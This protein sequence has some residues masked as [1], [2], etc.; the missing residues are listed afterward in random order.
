MK[1]LPLLFLLLISSIKNFAQVGIGTT[2]PDASSVLDISGSNKGV[3]LPKVALTNI[4]SA[5]PIANP[6]I[7]LLIYNTTT[8]GTTPNNLAPGYYVWSGVRWFP[9]INKG[10]NPGDMQYWDGTKWIMIP[11]GANGSVLTICN[12]IPR[13]GGCPPPVIDT[14]IPANNLYEGDI[15]STSP[16]GWFGGT[17][18]IDLHA[19]TVGGNPIYRRI[20]I[21]FNYPS[22]PVGTI[23]DSCKLYFYSSPVPQNGNGVDAQYGANSSTVQRITTNW[24]TPG[25]FSWTNLPTVTTTNQVIIPQSATNTENAVLDVTQL[26]KDQ[27]LSGN[28]GFYLKLQTEAIYRC[29]QYASSYHPDPTKRPKLVIWRH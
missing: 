26:V 4:D 2:T 16:T 18:Q 13:W 22:L 21:K 27:Y 20:C 23:I 7:G 15:E 6:A 12:G 28:N 19:W 9:V 25:Q 24:T 11:V 8:A 1:Y 14:L 5:F 3:L 10:I 29:H 17:I